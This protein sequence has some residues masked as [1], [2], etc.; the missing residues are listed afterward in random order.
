[1]KIL[2]TG[3]NGFLGSALVERL[4][5]HGEVDIRC[6]VRQETTSPRLAGWAERFPSAN[7]EMFRGDLTSRRDV[8][9][10]LV[11]VGVVYHLAAAMKGSAAD[12]FLD[13]VVGS[14]NL[15][16]GL[17]SKRSTRVILVSTFGAYGAS[18][19]PSGALI[20]ETTPLESCPDRRDLYSH[21][22]LRQELLFREYHDNYG[23]PLVVLRPGPIYGPGGRAMSTRVGI[24][25]F[26]LFLYMGRNNALPLTYV[27]NCAEAIVIAGR[28]GGNEGEAYNVV[29][30]DA[31]TAKEFF[32]LY[33]QH[34]EK[35]RYFALPYR[36]TQVLSTLI[37]RYNRH[38][39]GQLPAILTPYKSA[40]L[41]K[42]NTFDN[43]KLK[44]IGWKQI[45]STEEGLMRFFSYLRDTRDGRIH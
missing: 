3:A 23:F 29:D 10:A 27:D 13:T 35:I 19:L 42:G 17:R 20:D 2:V 40:Y 45:V 33:R 39:K 31:P 32:R 36:A 4:L 18:G 1:M 34:V 25:L 11:D 15:L 7:V 37:E 43:G 8:E 12:M 30:D 41:W 16:E 5:V 28:K 22:K 14:K 26:G 24:P 38:S 21:T 6:F 44:G 9:N